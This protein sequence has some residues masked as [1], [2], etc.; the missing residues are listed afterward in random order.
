MIPKILLHGRKTVVSHVIVRII[1]T[2]LWL[3][4]NV[5]NGGTLHAPESVILLLIGTGFVRNAYRFVAKHVQY[6]LM[7]RAVVP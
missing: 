7:R 2:I 3:V 6:D 5:T 1:S 4:T